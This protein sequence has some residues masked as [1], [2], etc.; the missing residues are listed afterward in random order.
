MAIE[1]SVLRCTASDYLFGIFKIFLQYAINIKISK[2]FLISA[3]H[4]LM[5][6]QTTVYNL[7]STYYKLHDDLSDSVNTLVKF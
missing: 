7:S 3:W 4:R 6:S 1:M 2:H 5:C